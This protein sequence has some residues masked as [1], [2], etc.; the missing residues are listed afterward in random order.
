MNSSKPLS[1]AEKLTSVEKIQTA[2]SPLSQSEE[3]EFASA[4]PE[5]SP[6]PIEDIQP[7]EKLKLGIPGGRRLA[8]R[9][10]TISSW[11]WSPESREIL[12]NTQNDGLLKAMLGEQFALEAGE[13]AWADLVDGKRKEL[14]WEYELP[15]MP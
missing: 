7:P 15:E 12:L 2:L 9:L 6:Q 11:E 10:D 3:R 4:P 8:I 1:P 14:Q 5:P 13:Q